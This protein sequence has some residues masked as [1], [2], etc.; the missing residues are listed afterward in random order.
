MV[1]VRH[2]NGPVWF[3]I[4]VAALISA[5]TGPQPILREDV[6]FA[7][8]GRKA[9]VQA[10]A[11]CRRQAKDAG[12]KHGTGKSGNMASGA[13]LGGVGGAAVGAA[14]G[15][16][17]GAAGVAIGAAVGAG[18]GALLGLLAG[19]YKP[20]EPDPVYGRFVARCLKEK[21]YE[22]IEWE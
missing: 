11:E 13:A 16:F 10:I 5:C 17:G 6:Q 15:A 20:V 1:R 3:T 9:A 21:G 19:A 8:R 22:V 7:L 12:V 4:L 18:T 14:G 2:L